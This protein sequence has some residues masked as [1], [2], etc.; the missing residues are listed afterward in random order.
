M[1]DHSVTALLLRLVGYL[2]FG[3]S[4]IAADPVWSMSEDN[5]T[6][7]RMTSTISANEC[8]PTMQALSSKRDAY[9]I[10][11]PIESQTVR[12]DLRALSPVN[13]ETSLLE[14]S[15]ANDALSR[16]WSPH[17]TSALT[18]TDT[19]QNKKTNNTTEQKASQSNSRPDRILSDSRIGQTEEPSPSEQ[20]D[21]DPE[22]GILRLRELPYDPADISDPELGNLRLRETGIRVTPDRPSVYLRGRVGFFWSDNIFSSEIDPVND[23]LFRTGLSLYAV[24]PIGQRT[25]LTALV[26]GELL[27]YFDETEFNY[28]ELQFS[29][30]V[31]HALTR[32]TYLDV[33]WLN[34]QLFDEVDNDRFLNDHQFRLAIGRRDRLSQDLYLN[35]SYQARLSLADPETRSRVFNLFHVSL[36]YEIQPRLRADVFYQFA[37]IDFTQQSRND[38]YHQ[39]IAQLSYQLSRS[40]QISI[41]GGARLGNSSDS[42]IDFD[43]GLFGINVGVNLPL[44]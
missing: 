40:T 7:T 15:L 41:F 6:F 29:L 30:G 14:S 35:T 44:F 18:L 27:R 4:L 17:A 33:K 1:L 5:N 25:Y 3:M 8:E 19:L 24:P 43:S 9:P 28:D 26:S 2:V 42:N 31:Y 36:G 10:E 34:Q 22:L 38:R 39:L 20:P 11:D 12:A 37:L 32:R 13:S 21:A 23:G 16:I